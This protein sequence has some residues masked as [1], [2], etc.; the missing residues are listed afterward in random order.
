MDF[1]TWLSKQPRATMKAI[2]RK[3][4]LGY[5]TI[6]SA[7][8]LLP[9]HHYPTAKELSDFTGGEVSVLELMDPPKRDG[10]P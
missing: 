5:S 2:E 4:G 8:K 7:K 3:T 10:R 6:G 1:S 9:L